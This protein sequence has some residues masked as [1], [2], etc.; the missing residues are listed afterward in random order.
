VVRRITPSGRLPWILRAD[1]IFEE[2]L[3]M[4]LLIHEV[5][6]WSASLDREPIA[7]RAPAVLLRT[8]FNEDAD[9]VWREWCPGIKVIEIAGDHGTLLD[10]ENPGSFRETFIIGTK[11]W[12]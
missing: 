5:A 8:C 7:L 4:R 10:S 2:E 11:E 3:S 6:P 1:P 9:S 12:Y